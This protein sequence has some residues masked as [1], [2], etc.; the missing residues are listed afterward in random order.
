MPTNNIK[1]G[2]IGHRKRYLSPSKQRKSIFFIFIQT[3]FLLFALFFKIF[4]YLC[5]HLSKRLDNQ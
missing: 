3:F 4:L 5:T 2:C 1:Y